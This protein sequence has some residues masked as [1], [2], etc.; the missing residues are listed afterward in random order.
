VKPFAF[1]RRTVS[2]EDRFA[3]ASVAVR[4][5]NRLCAPSSKQVGTNPPEDPNAAADPN[6]LMAFPALGSAPRVNGLTITN[7]FGTVKLD[8]IRRSFLL[9]PTSKDLNVPPPALP[10]PPDHFQCYLVRR[11]QGSASFAKIP[12]LAGV[13]QF[14]SQNFDIL[15]P[16]YLCVPA[17]KNDEDPGAVGHLENLLCYKARHRQNFPELEPHVNNQFLRDRVK[18]IRRMEFCVPS[19]IVPVN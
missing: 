18:V 7:Q 12:N 15:R 6:H 3:D 11:S 2:V 5:P 13:D 16:R 17:N 8:A 4:S 14:G 9:T 19:T 10:D 1:A